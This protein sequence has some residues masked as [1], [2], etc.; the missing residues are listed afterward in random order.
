[1]KKTLLFMLFIGIL[2]NSMF[3]QQQVFKTQGH[4]R[5]ELKISK[6]QQNRLRSTLE[7]DKTFTFD[8]IKFW[9]GE[10]NKRAAL[11]IDWYDDKGSTLVWGFK[12]SGTATGFDMVTAI[13]KADPRLLFFT[14]FTGSLGNTI[15]GFGYDLNN[16]GGQYLIFEGNTAAPYY[17]VDGIVT[18]TAYNYD[19]WTNGD[20]ADHWKSGW[21]KG[22]W[23]YQV[24]DAQADDFNYS[25]L[26]A[27]SR[28]LQ[29]GSWDGWGYQDFDNPSWEGVIPRAPYQAAPIPHVSVTGLTLNHTTSTL[30]AGQTLQLSGTIQPAN[31]TNQTVVWSSN[32]NAIATVS[33]DGL[34]TTISAGSC[35]ITATTDE[36]S[37]QCVLTVNPLSPIPDY[38]SYWSE[39]GKDKN[40]LAI[41]DT[42]LA[43]KAE[44]LS[45][46]WKIQLSSLW[47]NG[48][49]PL[50]VNGNIYLAINSKV[51]II[52]AQTDQTL[53]E[54]TLAGACGFFSMVAYGE[55]KIF[56]PMNNGLL[57]AFNAETL[58]SL[59]VTE[60]KTGYQ[61]LC[62]VVYH[63][64]YVYTGTWK[65][66]AST[67]GTYYCVLAADEDPY[68]TNEIKNYTW[69]SDNTGF[70]WTGGTVVGDEIIFGGD[71]GILQSCNRKTGTLIDT[72]QI[73]PELTVSTIRCGSSYDPATQR[74]FFTGKESKKIYGVKINTDGTFDKNSIISGTALGQATT[75]P[76]VYNG[77][78]YATS[79]TMTSGGGLDVFDANTLE[80]IYA[81]NIGGISQATPLLTTAYATE[82]NNHTVYVYVTLNNANGSIVCIKDFE[83]NTEPIVQFTYKP[84]SVQYSTHSLVAD[85]N[86]TIYY[87]NDAKYL[88]ALE[89]TPSID[90]TGLS[91]NVSQHSVE[92]GTTY[93]LTVTVSPNNATTKNIIWSSNNNAIATVDANGLVTAV[94]AGTAIITA[95]TEDG[96]FTATCSITVTKP[97]VYVAE[98]S[99]SHTSASLT[100]GEKLALIATIAPSNANNK[101]LSWS[102][103]DE[104]VATVDENGTVTAGS[105][106]IANIT[107]KT[108]DGGFIAVCQIT[109]SYPT[110]LDD[111]KNANLKVYPTVTTGTIHIVQPEMN[112]LVQIIDYSGQIVQTEKLQAG[113]NTININ[114]NAKGVYFVKVGT[115]VTK[116]IKQ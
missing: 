39:M 107:A 60:T 100:R 56:V 57:Q 30:K 95:M 64:G 7:E 94:S 84:S 10:G 103:D 49:Q 41:V 70:Y 3:A 89:S 113:E 19:D 8:D 35:T 26:G 115:R 102:S 32:N 66:G 78:V 58:E 15:A 101:T 72:Y 29:D 22:Y 82:A 108:T 11:V 55:G 99:L 74:I 88:F 21:Y 114:S 79:G 106:G 83:G 36:I 91:L 16:S 1:M 112:Q 34:I 33:E 40:H 92:K 59:W 87:K 81:V 23:S 52:D 71:S 104:T 48:G 37:Q 25:G 46:K 116:V 45:E 54:N 2:I 14:H 13:A 76:T 65:G 17:P 28:E 4:P 96:G 73:A 80:K 9:V 86:G 61:H 111:V 105:G 42:K 24:K 27:S 6:T 51:M 93:Q 31:A 97:V 90:V 38:T 5:P 69:E 85:E 47:M 67:T 109:V 18:T 75:V 43:R 50:I 68:S 62:P 12:W 44:E 110:G 63:D 77:R 98:I 53:K 20:P